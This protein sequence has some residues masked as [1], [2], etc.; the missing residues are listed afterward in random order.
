MKYVNPSL[1]LSSAHKSKNEGHR[2]YLKKVSIFL[3]FPCF[4]PFYFIT[5][6]IKLD[7]E[8]VLSCLTHTTRIQLG[9]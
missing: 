3:K 9:P 1:S 2:A 8:T 5:F 6:Q 7:S 4:D